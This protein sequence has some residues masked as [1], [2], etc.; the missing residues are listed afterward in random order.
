MS[1]KTLFL[2]LCVVVVA[3]NGIEAKKTYIAFVK[4][5]NFFEAWQDCNSYD[6]HLATVRSAAEQSLVEQAV[7]RTSNPNG[8][9]FIGGTDLGRDGRWMW[10]GF[11]KVIESTDYRN[12]Y[13]GEPNNNG[14]SQECLAIGNF[15]DNRG[16]WDDIECIAKF[17]GYVCEFEVTPPAPFPRV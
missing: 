15:A 16:K 5:S 11:N 12:F 8:I 4:S 10:I 17:A 7:A 3:M 14:G 6:A 2:S 13:P 9:Y 1:F